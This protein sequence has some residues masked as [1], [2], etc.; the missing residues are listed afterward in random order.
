MGEVGPALKEPV[1]D[2]EVRGGPRI[3]I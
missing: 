3:W 1:C 2:S